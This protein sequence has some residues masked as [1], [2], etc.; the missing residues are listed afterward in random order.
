MHHRTLSDLPPEL[1]HIIVSQVEKAGARACSLTSRQIRAVAVE[2]V[3]GDRVKVRIKE[4]GTTDHLV[5][6]LTD[7]PRVAHRIAMLIVG[8]YDRDAWKDAPDYP[9]VNKRDVMK[10]MKAVPNLDTLSLWGFT[11]TESPL[12]Q[13][14]EGIPHPT[15]PFPLQGLSLNAM[16]TPSTLAGLFSILSLFNPTSLSFDYFYRF[17]TTRPLDCIDRQLPIGNLTVDSGSYKDRR[18]TAMLLDALSKT[19]QD[20]CLRRLRVRC[21]SHDALR[22]LGR[23]LYRAGDRLISLHLRIDGPEFMGQEEIWIDPL[24]D[25]WKALNIPACTSL[26]SIE[27]PIYLSKGQYHLSQKDLSEPI[28]NIMKEAPPTLKTITIRIV[29]IIRPTTLN[30]RSVLGLHHLDVALAKDRFPQLTTV[31]IDVEPAR[32]LKNKGGNYWQK[33]VAA[34]QRALPGLHARGLLKTVEVW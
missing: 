3:F 34:V 12:I 25:T 19:V 9:S 27:I 5:R 16:H 6:F 24:R 4:P 28:I 17:D 32:S 14:D 8:V 26:E 22:A 15:T 10:L 2:F 29:G 33:C 7:N 13:D 30:N 1:I 23:L 18:C 21:D 31:E 20:A 11:I